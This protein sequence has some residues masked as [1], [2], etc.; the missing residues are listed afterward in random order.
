MRGITKGFENGRFPLRY[1]QED[2]KHV[3]LTTKW[4]EKF[5]CK[6]WSVLNQDLVLKENNELL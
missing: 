1:E 5:L 6:K 4:R 3:L 2:D